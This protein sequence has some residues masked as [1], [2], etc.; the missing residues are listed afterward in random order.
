M[1]VLLSCL[2]V[3]IQVPCYLLVLYPDAWD[4]R[5]NNWRGVKFFLLPSEKLIGWATHFLT[6]SLL[7]EY[8]K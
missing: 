3:M 2:L 1:S 7:S 8:R 5:V 4:P 6:G